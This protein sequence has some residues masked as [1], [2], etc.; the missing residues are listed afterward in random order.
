MHQRGIEQG[1]LFEGSKVVRAPQLQKEVTQQAID[2]L[3]NWLKALAK[4]IE[5]EDVGDEQD[6]R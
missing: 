2:V 1:Q 4:T 3:T 6:R 5:T